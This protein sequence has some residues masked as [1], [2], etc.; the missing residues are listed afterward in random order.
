MKKFALVLCM[1]FLASCGREVPDE[2]QI[3][4]DQ[5]QIEDAVQHYVLGLRRA[6]RGEAI[7]TDSL[8]NALFEP[9]SVYVTYWG[10]TEP[11]DST[12]SRLRRSLPLISHY[13]SRAEIMSVH[14][15]GDMG[16]VFFILRQSYQT[17][18]SA[19]NEYL[20]TTYFFRKT[21]GDWKVIHAHRSADMETLRR[22]AIA[23]SDSVTFRTSPELTER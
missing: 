17:P 8:T 23:S 15:N 14:V 16:Y 5:A 22:Y 13:E 20:P 3:A 18:N 12:K 11:V 9:T 6:F 10:T 1:M 19:M 2:S 4:A 7:D 21:G